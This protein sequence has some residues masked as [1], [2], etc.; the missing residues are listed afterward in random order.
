MKRSE[1]EVP[2][3]DDDKPSELQTLRSELNMNAKTVAEAN[4]IIVRFCDIFIFVIIVKKEKRSKAVIIP[5]SLKM[6]FP[7]L[8]QENRGAVIALAEAAEENRALLEEAFVRLRSA[9]H[10][11]V[12]LLSLLQG[13]TPEQTAILEATLLPLLQDTPQLGWEESCDAAVSHLL[14]TCLSWSPKDQATSLAQAGGPVLSLPHDTARLKK[15]ITLLCDRI[16]K[17]GRLTLASEAN[18]PVPAQVQNLAAPGGVEPIA[19]GAGGGE[20]LELP[21]EATKFIRKKQ[22]SKKVKKERYIDEDKGPFHPRPSLCLP[23]ELFCQQQRESA[24]YEPLNN[25]VV[26]I[27]GI[28][29]VYLCF[30]QCLWIPDVP[31]MGLDAQSKQA[32]LVVPSV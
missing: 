12:L 31:D 15:H 16:G 25:S 27:I 11:L 29:A 14:R 32:V 21:Q 7:E 10:L 17:G 30:Y 19:E 8:E 2:Q 22:P 18:A 3:P 24:Q 20:E 1:A 23:G 6:G 28:V 13:L 5:N 26:E 4:V 9:T